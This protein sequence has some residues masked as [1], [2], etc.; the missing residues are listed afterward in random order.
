LLA[1]FNYAVDIAKLPPNRDKTG[2]ARE[3]DVAT[4]FVENEDICTGG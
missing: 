1:E 2:A 3:L 4:R